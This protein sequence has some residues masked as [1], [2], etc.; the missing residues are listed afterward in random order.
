MTLLAVTNDFH[1]SL[2]EGGA[3]LSRLNR[4]RGLGALVV[5]SGDFF[6]G[7]AFHCYGGGRDERRLLRELYDVVT[8][9]NHD[10]ADLELLD[11]EGGGPVRLCGNLR[12]RDPRHREGWRR[13]LLVEI[14]GVRLGLLGILGD[15]AFHAAPPAER[16]YYEF[17]PP[18]LREVNVHADDLRMRGADFVVALSHQGFD[19][20]RELVLDGADLDLVL[21]GHCHSD[22]Y[23]WR[24]P[25]GRLR[26][27]KAPECGQGL[28]TVG[29]DAGGDLT[30]HVLHLDAGSETTADPPW[31]GETLAAYDT[32]ARAGLGHVPVGLE[33]RAA[34]AQAVA[35]TAA[36]LVGAEG[37]VLNLGA[38]R[39]GLAGRLTRR[40]LHDCLPFDAPIV[41]VEGM[42]EGGT[43]TALT[44]SMRAIGETPVTAGDLRS[45]HGTTATT[46]YV[47]ERLGLAVRPQRD[48]VTLHDVVHDLCRSSQ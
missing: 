17:R 19:M 18:N 28:A 46:G 23:E 16:A 15:Q 39:G 27:V 8:P 35:S 40:G 29:L 36:G 5:D 43:I 37:F 11:A 10:L 24:D 38:V 4:L 44:S 31:L 12:P 3:V 13:Q 34:A 20:D 25:T 45:T 30:A 32:W 6:G 21:S 7:N 2:P 47:A 42:P 14:R 1:S 22:E 33:D 9:G 41:M 26:V 48:G